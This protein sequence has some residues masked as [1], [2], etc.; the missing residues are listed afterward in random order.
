MLKTIGAGT[1]S[2]R[3]LAEYLLA[4][5]KA[6]PSHE[7]RLQRYLAGDAGATRALVFGH[8][9][10][11][12]CDQLSWHEAM[13]RTRVRWGKERPTDKRYEGKKWRNYY[14]WAIS[15]APDDRASAAEVGDLTRSWLERMWPSDDGWEWVYSVHADNAGR[16]MHAHVVLNA[17]N[18]ET[19]RKVQIG[20]R[21]SDRLADELQDIAADYGMGQL[22]HLADRRRA[23]AA[24]REVESVTYCR[25]SAAERA[26]RARG[27]RSWVAEIR[28]AID[29]AVSE[30]GDFEEFRARMEHDGFRVERSRRGLGFR[31]PDSTGHDKKVLASRL[32]TDY[33]DE[34]IRCRLSFAFDEHLLDAPVEVRPS[35]GHAGRPD[36]IAV[37]A[38]RGRVP[39][40]DR[41]RR[42]LLEQITAMVRMGPRRSCARLESVVDAIST[43]K[44]EGIDSTAK[45]ARGVADATELVLSLEREVSLMEDGFEAASRALDA[46]TAAREARAELKGLPEGHWDKE[47]RI[48]RNELLVEIS[49]R[50]DEARRCLEKASAFIESRGLGAASRVDQAATLVREF[51]SRSDGIRRRSEDARAKLRKLASAEQVVD[52]LSGKKVQVARGYGGARLISSGSRHV[53][54]RPDGGQLLLMGHRA[55]RDAVR[56]IGRMMSADR[57]AITANPATA[58][59]D[60]RAVAQPHTSAVGQLGEGPSI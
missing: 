47:T 24:G 3:D 13:R 56:S 17:V 36:P 25:M 51:G 15:P 54:R 14:H 26:M 55:Q 16:I 43:V 38:G 50:D 45:L 5:E 29:R 57:G 52:A 19:G 40:K 21:L 46:A 34:G 49:D 18:A 22:P 4:G 44:E 41:G 33:T 8:S 10:N 35:D 30:S 58:Q 60:M 28:D 6:D 48:R 32:G 11:M 1:G 23:L 37:L 39:L 12:D 20:S 59:P 42:G 9:E 7:A 53:R 27:Q 2:C 31:H